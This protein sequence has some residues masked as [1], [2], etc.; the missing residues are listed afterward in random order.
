[1]TNIRPIWTPQDSIDTAQDFAAELDS[2]ERGCCCGPDPIRPLQRQ[3][4]NRFGFSWLFSRSRER[5]ARR[6]DAL[7]VTLLMAV[8]AA[9]GCAVLILSTPQAKAAPQQ[10]DAYAYAA[11]FGLVVCSVLDDYSSF[12][13]IA[14][15]GQALAGEGWTGED[16]GRIVGYSVMEFCPQHLPLIKRFAAEFGGQVAA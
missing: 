8:M 14:G 1:M 3:S 15:I 6:M 5:R 12:A 16:T 9:L 13:G 4:R 7:A 11:T 10:D 2:A